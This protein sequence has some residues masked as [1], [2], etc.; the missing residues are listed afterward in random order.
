MNYK[1]ITADTTFHFVIL[2][3]GAY[4]E[5]KIATSILR[6]AAF[7]VCCDGAAVHYHGK[8]AAIVGDGDSLPDDF[9]SIYHDII[10][11]V[12][13][14]E[15]NDLTKATRYCLEHCQSIPLAEGEKI[16]IAYLG[17]TG[18]REDHAIGN[19]SLMMRYATEFDIEPV[20][21]TDYGY[22]IACPKEANTL[23]NI[24]SFESFPKQ[25]FS[26]FNFGCTS[27]CGEGF[28]WQPYAYKQLW[29]GTLNEAEGDEVKLLGDGDYMIFA[30]F[31]PKM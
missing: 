8:P 19:F 10:V 28:R 22:F 14:Q 17:T 16:R 1:L 25:Q 18:E 3:N 31:D 26:I 11:H 9:K 23:E 30:T 20:M 2:A 24:N 5:G 4:P 15:D 12:S 6:Q 29:Q 13:E 7:V 27:L 21:I